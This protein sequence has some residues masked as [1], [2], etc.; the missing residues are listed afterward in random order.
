MRLTC[1]VK[2]ECNL[3]LLQSSLD[4]PAFLLEESLPSV[5]RVVPE[6]RVFWEGRRLVPPA[7]WGAESRSLVR[8]AVPPAGEERRSR[9]YLSES[10]N[11]SQM[12]SGCK[13]MG[14][15]CEVALGLPYPE[16]HVLYPGPHLYLSRAR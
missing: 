9:S 16:G 7:K 11:L 1:C 6:A 13:I 3:P 5:R 12:G 14:S 2:W 4:S 10:Y 8:R 15:H